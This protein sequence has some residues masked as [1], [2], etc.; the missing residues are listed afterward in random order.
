MQNSRHGNDIVLAGLPR[1]GSTLTCHLINKLPDAVALNEPMST[2]RFKDL[3]DNA[4][5]CDAISQ[6]LVSMRGSLET[7]G[8]ALSKHIDG[9]VPDNPVVQKITGDGLRQGEAILGEISFRKDLPENFTLV[10]KHPSTFAALLPDLAKRFT[11]FATIRNP[12]AVLSSWNSVSM[13][14]R[15]GRAPKGEN[16]VPE[17]HA[18][19]N[20]LPDRLDRQVHLLRWFFERFSALP[21]E[22]VIRY[23]DII[24]SS[25]TCLRVLSES[26]VCLEEPLESRNRSELYDAELTPI[27]VERLLRER[28]AAFW[29]FYS[30][31]SVEA[32]GD[33]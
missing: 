25:G 30:Q 9:L 11:T 8:T 15:D 1:S 17:L 14:I 29:D 31:S 26:A 12:V 23:E 2:R 19:L 16:M 27:L 18:R 5:I 3:P 6:F 28:D 22:R 24:A 10:V 20:A 13:P 32:F 21:A 33:A 4:A 7:S